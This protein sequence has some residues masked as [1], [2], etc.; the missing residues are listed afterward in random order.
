MAMLKQAQVRG[1][2]E[3]LE[4]GDSRQML[5][6][7]FADDTGLILSA[8]EENWNRATA[9]VKKFE[10]LSGA[11]LNVAKSLVVPIGEFLWG[12]TAEGASKKALVSWEKICRMKEVGGLGLV[13]FELQARSLKMRLVTKLL[14]NEDL[15]WVHIAKTILTWKILDTRSRSNEIGRPVQETLI[16]GN[17]MRLGDTPTLAKILEGWWAARPHLSLND[18]APLPGGIRIEQGLTLLADKYKLQQNEIGSYSSLC[19]KAGM[20]YLDDIQDEGLEMLTGLELNSGR[21]PHNTVAYGPISRFYGLVADQLR[22]RRSSQV[23]MADSNLWVWIKDSKSL[24]GWSHTTREW[25]WLLQNIKTFETKLNGRWEVNWSDE[26]WSNLWT[27]LW[28]GGLFLRDKTWT[29]RILHCGIFVHEKLIRMG[30]GDGLCPRGCAQIETADHCLLQCT[31]PR[32]RWERLKMLIASTCGLQDPTLDFVRWLESACNHTTHSLPLMLLFI[33]HTRHAWRERC[34]EVF[35]RSASCLPVTRIIQE[36]ADLANEIEKNGSNR[37]RKEATEAKTYLS[38]LLEMEKRNQ[39]LFHT[40]RPRTQHFGNLSESTS[41][42]SST[43]LASNGRNLSR[44]SSS[45]GA[46]VSAASDQ[47]C[48]VARTQTL[49]TPDSLEEELANLGF[50]G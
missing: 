18:G 36:A 31:K 17:Q 14:E 49:R 40:P 20:E 1:Q 12:R 3:G 15:D 29:W 4:L 41:S 16:L 10:L 23:S 39:M 8:E 7:L 6:A 5:E 37:T 32:R 21:M 33:A 27:K 22:G 46:S 13:Y 35:Q 9:V 42:M 48:S 11:K 30:L 25:R 28:G 19:L 2:V 50:I 47:E 45:T 24:Q 43:L 38:S 34:Q 44:G 26:R